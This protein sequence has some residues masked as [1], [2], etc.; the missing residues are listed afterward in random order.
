M[1]KA[2]TYLGYLFS[3]FIPFFFS[4]LEVSFERRF[5]IPIGIVLKFEFMCE[6]PLLRYLIFDL[7][8]NGFGTPFLCHNPRKIQGWGKGKRMLLSLICHLVYFS[9]GM[10]LVS[11]V[12][13]WILNICCQTYWSGWLR[14]KL[15]QSIKCIICFVQT[16]KQSHQI[17]KAC[18]YQILGFFCRKSHSKHSQEFKWVVNIG[19]YWKWI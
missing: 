11:K 7:I 16:P 2:L 6:L 14:N 3:I 10:C 8:S 17:L 18:L 4:I 12:H 9:T 19:K 15:F 1:R 5:N 13:M